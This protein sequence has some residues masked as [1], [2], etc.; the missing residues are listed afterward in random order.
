MKPI[1]LYLDWDPTMDP[2][3]TPMTATNNPGPRP[4]GKKRLRITFMAPM[5]QEV[6]ATSVSANIP[7]AAVYDETAKVGAPAVSIPAE[8][9]VD[10]HGGE[11]PNVPG[12]ADFKGSVTRGGNSGKHYDHVARK[13]GEKPKTK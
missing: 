13:P 1:V 2:E 7:A 3:K 8:G 12:D 9:P 5:P 11:E 10:A 6:T 4:E